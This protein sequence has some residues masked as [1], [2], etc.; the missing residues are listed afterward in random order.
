[1]HA[2]KDLEES[3]IVAL[4]PDNKRSRKV[5]RWRAYEQGESL[6]LVC[7]TIPII[8]T[9]KIVE[10]LRSPKKRV[11]PNEWIFFLSEHQK[12][13]D[14]SART[15]LERGFK[16][17]VGYDLS[18]K[19]LFD[20]DE[21][22]NLRYK[23]IDCRRPLLWKAGIYVVPIRR[24]SELTPDGDEILDIRERPIGEVLCD[25]YKKGSPYK[26]FSPEEFFKALEKHTRYIIA[27]I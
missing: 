9:D 17:E 1:M 26:R 25:V 6:P 5:Q 14:D 4:N 16:E 22:I 8:G 21:R 7:A 11:M 3:E 24:L 2:L 12:A 10:L 23:S 18:R 20:P 13:S 15:T 19:R 27:N